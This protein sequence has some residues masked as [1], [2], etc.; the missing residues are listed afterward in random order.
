MSVDLGPINRRYIRNP[1][2]QKFNEGKIL[3]F[4]GTEDQYD[5]KDFVPVEIEAGKRN[6][7]NHHL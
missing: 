3:I 7:S 4:I 5:D 6:F 1:N 2:E